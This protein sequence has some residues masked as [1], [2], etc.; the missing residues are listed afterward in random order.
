MTWGKVTH[1]QRKAIHTLLSKLDL[2]EEKEE[3][4]AKYSYTGLSSTSLLTF[5]EAGNLIQDLKSQLPDEEEAKQKMI[6][7]I[8]YYG[9]E[10]GFDKPGDSQQGLKKSKI[11]FINCN[12]WCLSPRSKHKKGLKQMNI[13]ELS[14]TVTQFE[15]MYKTETKALAQ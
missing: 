9:Y 3:I 2:M 14:D 7:K 15:Q 4:V 12:A 13:K 1:N 6:R 8:L 5:Q 10:L 11:N